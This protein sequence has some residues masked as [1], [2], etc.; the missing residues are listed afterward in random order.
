VDSFN[1]EHWT[2]TTTARSSLHWTSSIDFSQQFLNCRSW[3]LLCRTFSDN[4]SGTVTLSTLKNFIIATSLSE[5]PISFVCKQWRKQW[6]HFNAFPGKVQTQIRSKFL[7]LHLSQI[8]MKSVSNWQSYNKMYN[9]FSS[10]ETRCICVWTTSLQFL[11]CI[12]HLFMYN[13]SVAIVHLLKT[14]T[15]SVELVSDKR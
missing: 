9:S 14:K 15:S 12:S 3:P 5:K 11:L 8:S 4:F 1:T 7:Q 10:F 2:R 6:R 13:I